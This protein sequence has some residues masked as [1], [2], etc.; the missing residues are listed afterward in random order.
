MYLTI[1]KEGIVGC[2]SSIHLPSCGALFLPS[3]PVV[4]VAVELQQLALSGIWF[5]SFFLLKSFKQLQVLICA[6]TAMAAWNIFSC[7]FG[8]PL[9]FRGE[10]AVFFSPFLSL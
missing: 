1:G 3:I 4:Q 9:D 2:A 10:K 8:S 6:V 5:L 7:S